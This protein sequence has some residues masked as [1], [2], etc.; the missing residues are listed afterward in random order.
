[1][2]QLTKTQRILLGPS[3]RDRTTYQRPVASNRS[4]AV[5]THVP[6]QI[7]I[8]TEDVVMEKTMADSP[9]LAYN[10]ADGGKESG[11]QPP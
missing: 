10:S 2:Q 7:T 3:R 8:E 9:C 1:M 6:Q 5:A 11:W 4:P